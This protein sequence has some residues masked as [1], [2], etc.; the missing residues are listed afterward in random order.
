MTVSQLFGGETFFAP[1]RR[2][3]HRGGRHGDSSDR[4]QGGMVKLF[5]DA[6]HPS[7]AIDRPIAGRAG[8]PHGRGLL[9]A[10]RADGPR[11]GRGR[12][13]PGCRDARARGLRHRPCARCGGRQPKDTRPGRDA[14]LRI[15]HFVLASRDQARRAADL[16]VVVV[17][18]PGFVDT[19]GDQY[20]D[21]WIIDGRPDLHVLPLSATCIDAGR[22]GRSCIRLPVRCPRPV[23]R[24]LGRECRE[25]HGPATSCITHRP[26]PPARRCG[27]RPPAPPRHSVASAEEGSL[28]PGKRANLVVLDRDPLDCAPSPS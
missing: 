18:N 3:P 21:R 2:G 8:R 1:P 26:S 25:G 23:P 7:P 15:E 6:V 20:I 10:R 17:T 14:L 16:G 19:W 13:R 24:H 27:C 22:H 28:E 11:A 9:R 5:V 12:A 4:L